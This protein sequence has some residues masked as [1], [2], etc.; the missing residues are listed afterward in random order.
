LNP[1]FDK[2]FSAV[3]YLLQYHHSLYGRYVYLSYADCSRQQTAAILSSADNYPPSLL[4]VRHLFDSVPSSSSSAF[5][6]VF[7]QH[8]AA[9]HLLALTNQLAAAA[10][11]CHAPAAGIDT[12]GQL[13]T[14]D[15]FR[16]QFGVAGVEGITCSTISGSTKLSPSLGGAV[17]RF[18]PYL[19]SDRR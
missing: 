6:S 14:V 16:Q 7:R 3:I 1:E 17:G 10:D 8:A 12:S 2:L 13:A 4:A 15:Y 11:R 9:A 19:S 5:S 18:H